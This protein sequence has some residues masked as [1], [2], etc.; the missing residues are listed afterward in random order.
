MADLDARY[1]IED[2]DWI[3]RV[4]TYLT[5][6]RQGGGNHQISPH[7]PVGCSIADHFFRHTGQG[8]AVEGVGQLDAGVAVVQVLRTT[9]HISMD[10]TEGVADIV[11]RTQRGQALGYHV[12]GHFFIFTEVRI[13][14]LSVEI[15]GGD[16]R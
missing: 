7:T 2:H 13:H 5:V 9:F 4:K 3:G 15:I 14:R 11:S 12:P 16:I 8:Y 10:R 6:P 1:G